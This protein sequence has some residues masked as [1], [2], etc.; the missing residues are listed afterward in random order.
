M[1]AQQTSEAEPHV[2]PERL[3]QFA[4]GYAP[5]LILAAAVQNRVFDA[6]ANG[7]RTLEE[8]EQF[9]GASRRG[10]EGILN[11]LIALAFLSKDDQGRYALTPESDAF[12]V[13]SRPGF[14]GGLFQHTT[15][16]ILPCWMHLT[17]VVR[18]GRPALSV[19]QET[20]GSEFFEAFVES[21]FPLS[22]PAAQ[23]LGDALGLGQAAAPVQVL[24][25]AAGSGVW[26]IAL[27]EKSPQVHVT[28]VDWPG[29]LAI[30]Q[31]VAAQHG[32]ADRLNVVEGDL[33]TCDF[34]QGYGIATLGHILHSEGADRSRA[35]L[36]KTFD[37]LAP[38]GTIAI[39]EMLAN[40]EH[41]GPPHAMIF[42]VNMLVSTEQG[43]TYSFGEISGWLRDV[44]FENSRTLDAPGPSPLIL[45][46]KP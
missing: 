39:A 15:A 13:S 28:A 31:K 7:S 44:G 24:D 16:Q 23:A 10:L 20:G 25:L 5:P 3:F 21:I 6:L 18:T 32:V 22:Y 30:T 17:D 12:L 4:F 37:A 29:V 41:T 46:T 14:L 38:G 36:Q 2:T 34:G 11:A 45:A 1:T 19:N 26:G 27:A 43:T 42:A 8:I 33:L 40:E 9:S 35:L